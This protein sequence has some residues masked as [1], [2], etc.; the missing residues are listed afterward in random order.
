MLTVADMR[1]GV[2]KITEKMLTYFLEGP[3]FV[4]ICCRFRILEY[5]FYVLLTFEK[6]SLH[7]V[8][9]VITYKSCGELF[10]PQKYILK[11]TFIV[12]S[13]FSKSTF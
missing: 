3:Y 13:L 2:S 6:I 5:I 1:E 9:K 11:Q 8:F 10:D 4:I 12:D 7:F